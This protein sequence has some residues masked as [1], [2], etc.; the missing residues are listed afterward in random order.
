MLKGIH[1]NK[2]IEIK[3]FGAKCKCFEENDESTQNC[4]KKLTC[5]MCDFNTDNE[6]DL[7]IHKGMRHDIK[8]KN[9]SVIFQSE[10]NCS[11]PFRL[12]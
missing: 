6:N 11:S 5:D 7:K 12:M 8:C 10:G 2:Q 9:Y 4:E 3:Q 1:E